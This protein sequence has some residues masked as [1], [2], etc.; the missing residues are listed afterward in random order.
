MKRGWWVVLLVSIGLNLGLGVQ[1]VRRPGPPPDRRV[2][3]PPADERPEPFVEPDSATVR[4][5]VER[6]LDRLSRALDLDPDQRS[7]LAAIQL[8]AGREIQQRKHAIIDRRRQLRDAYVSGAADRD[9]LLA[10]QRTV[11]RLQASL[12]SLLVETMIWEMGVLR[13]EQR[14]RYHELM[15]WGPDGDRPGHRRGRGEGP[16][17]GDRHGPR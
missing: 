9:R 2:G 8:S 13:P 17:R 3:P 15:P 6:R 7:Q 4:R 14:E 11:S 12:D 5:F 1:L 16:R 10:E